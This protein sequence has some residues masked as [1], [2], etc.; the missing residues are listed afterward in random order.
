MHWTATELYL[1]LLACRCDRKRYGFRNYD[2]DNRNGRDDF[3]A[4]GTAWRVAA[5]SPE[6][7]WGVALFGLGGLLSGRKRWRHCIRCLQILCAVTIL[8]H[9]LGC[10][11]S[12]SG[13]KMPAAVTSTV[14]ITA[15]A[16]S[17]SHATT[18][19]LTVQ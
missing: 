8:F 6:I 4:A 14:T 16:E 2:S 5:A 9:L 13:N 17:I 7:I 19:I 18:V 10:G 1:Q 11:R 12:S 3:I 15:S